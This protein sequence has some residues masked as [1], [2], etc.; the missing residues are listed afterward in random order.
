M[1]KVILL[2]TLLIV[3]ACISD[4]AKDSPS[5]FGSD[6]FRTKNDTISKQILGQRGQGQQTKGRKALSRGS[7]E[8]INNDALKNS[9]KSAAIVVPAGRDKVEMNLINA[10]IPAAAQAVLGDT[11]KVPFVVSDAVN[12]RV[13]VQTTGAIP[14]SALLD[15]F[16]ITLRANG[17]RMEKEGK[18]IKILPGKQGTRRFVSSRDSSAI[19]GDAIVV[20]P[21]QFISASQMFQLLKPTIEDGLKVDV[22]KKRN[23]LL[24]SGDRPALEAGLDAI[25]LFDVN[26]M[27][28]KSI[29]LVNLDAADPEAVVKE[30]NLI[31]ETGSGGSLE[32]VVEF[33]PNP[34]LRSILV[35]TSR[36]KYLAEA[37]RWIRDLDRT[38]G[39]AN[40][41]AEIYELQNRSASDLAPVLAGL[42][43][44][45]SSSDY[46]STLETTGEGAIEPVS[47][48]LEN[49]QIQVLADDARNAIIARALKNE[50][51][52]IRRLINRLDSSAKQVLIE[53]TLAEV[54]LNDELNLG[55]RWYLQSGNFTNTFSDVTS[56]AVASTFPGFST[57]FTANS[58]QAAINA[59]SSVTDVKV[60]SSPTLTVLDNKEAE[61]Q[62]GDQVPIATRSSQSTI[63]PNAPIVSTIEYRDTGVI[64][65]VKPRIGK[66]GRVVME[67]EQEVSDV[68]NTT[69]SGIDSPTIRQREIKTSVVVQNG[70]TLAL[71]GIIQEQKNSTTSK[72]PGAGDIPLLGALFRNKSKTAARTELLILIRPTVINDVGDSRAVTQHWREKLKNSNHIINSGLGSPKH[73]LADVLD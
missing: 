49:D 66:G 70:D 17:A 32:D 33:V 51:Q 41:Y 15:L 18:V 39:N 6:T 52:E 73:T 3:S 71:G 20:A 36:S 58:A 69:T 38:A 34:R 60:I 56:G 68:A 19:S 24:L 5:R 26:I 45:A 43:G 22:D 14:Q 11:L 13:T 59:L 25:N 16:E 21:L 48:D 55:V 40:R 8:F 35:I 27:R 57:L 72:V 7:D 63:D 31:F 47:L 12:G 23:L 29:A 53:V 61:L 42:L 46:S 54:T 2:L 1:N 44:V 9:G 10:S 4:Q 64:M 50:H 67:I 62:I 37:Q 65:R 28:G 30:L